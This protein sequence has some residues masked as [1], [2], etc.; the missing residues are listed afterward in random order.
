M[1]VIVVVVLLLT[2]T[3][4]FIVE[5][6]LV[7]LDDCTIVPPPWPVAAVIEVVSVLLLVVVD[8]IFDRLIDF[9]I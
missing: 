8:S 7:S 1:V 3:C 6:R 2:A 9:L 4:G 5:L